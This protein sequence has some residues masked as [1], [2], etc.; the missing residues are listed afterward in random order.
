MDLKNRDHLIQLILKHLAG[1]LSEAEGIELTA[2][3]NQS[4]RHRRYF[5]EWC[6]E[7]IRAERQEKIRQY[8]VIEGW[9]ETLKKKRR[10]RLVLHSLQ[11]A[12]SVIIL[13]GCFAIYR[14]SMHAAS[15]STP[16]VENIQPGKRTA[17]L[18]TANGEIVN[19]D[20]LQHASLQN[21][22]VRNQEGTLFFQPKSDLVGSKQTY[23]RI[24]VPRGGEFELKLP[25]GTTVF[26]NAETQLRFPE[27]F[28]PGKERVV[29]L[30]GEAYFDVVHDTTSPFIVYT[31]NTSVKVLGTS[32]NIMAYPSQ[33]QEETTL[34]NGSVL[35][36]AKDSGKS[37]RLAPGQ[38]GCY[39]IVR[40]SLSSQEVETGYFTSW[41]DGIFAFYQQPLE[42]VMETLGRWYMFDIVYQNEK[43]KSV[44]YT[45]KI[46]RHASIQEVLHI[47]ELL[48]EVRFE[49]HG[50]QVIV[51]KK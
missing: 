32:F 21:L 5:D 14:Y 48:D 40:K 8:D 9:N 27:H 15:Q 31:E 4:G 2:W 19:L 38:Q 44:A 30:A 29:Y 16:V 24:E 10:H 28:I 11:I 35:L 45:G 26:L 42:K 43:I 39:D 34:V 41:K 47:L 49:I 36:C 18:L 20:T 22:T 50:N 51:A 37:V 7:S 13:L 46:A 1:T 3:K 17:R 33:G 23:N 6:D 12:A 25:D